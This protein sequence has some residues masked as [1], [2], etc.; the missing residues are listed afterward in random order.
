MTINRI[1]IN[2]LTNHI[3]GGKTIL[4]P[5]LRTKDAILFQYLEEKKELISPAPKIFP[6]DIFIQDL[7]EL[8][9]GVEHQTAVLLGL[10]RQR[11][12]L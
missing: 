10:Y 4:V 5:N 7:W 8:T 1:N 3:D 11:K 2:V 12:R 6:I 9:L